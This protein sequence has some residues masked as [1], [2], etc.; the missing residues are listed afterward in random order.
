MQALKALVIGM[1][2]LIVIGLGFVAYGLVSRASKLAPAE[3]DLGDISLDLPVGCA[4]A[5]ARAEAGRLIVR[6]EGPGERGCQQILV[7]DLESGKI[8]GRIHA[9]TR[10]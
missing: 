9:G 4:I 8:L 5:E 6:A 1:G 2:I 7:I 10:Q 3:A